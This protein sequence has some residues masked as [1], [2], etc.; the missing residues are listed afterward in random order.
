MTGLP[1]GEP[2]LPRVRLPMSPD[3][4]RRLRAG[5]LVL[6][7]GE[8]LAT[9]GMPTHRRMMAE[10]EA[11]RP[12]PTPMDG[13]AFFH[14]GVC[15][16]EEPAGPGRLHYVNPTTSTRF[17][18]MMPTLIRRFGLTAVGGK[19]GLSRDSVEAMRDV[20]C[21]YFSFVGGASAL[22]SLGVTE[23]V[24]AAWPDLIMQFR[25]NRIRLAGLGPV[26]VAIDAHGESV[27]DRLQASATARL[28]DILQ[29][30]RSG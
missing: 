30:V 1:A 9:V 22:L 8:A 15:Y 4:A 17:N 3:E 11:G 27:Y 23:V 19:G 5:D 12:M 24:E 10:I 21:V 7:D 26:T 6:L 16:D 14:M 25:L 29:S 13:G 18:G 20:G 28:A 2:G